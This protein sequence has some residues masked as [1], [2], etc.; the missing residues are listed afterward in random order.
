MA[1]SGG[2]AGDCSRAL[3]TI[4]LGKQFPAGAGGHLTCGHSL[5]N[6]GLQS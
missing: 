2:T 5:R 1:G 4:R 3:R 6:D